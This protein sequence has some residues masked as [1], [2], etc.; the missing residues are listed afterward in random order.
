MT[1]RLP[2]LLPSLAAIVPPLPLAS[3]SEALLG[4]DSGAL[5][6]LSVDE[7]KKERLQRLHE[8]QGEAGPVAGL[9][10]VRRPQRGGAPAMLAVRACA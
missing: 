6:E 1:A 8:L 7:G 2:C 3:C 10:Q 9:A 5:Y 4:T